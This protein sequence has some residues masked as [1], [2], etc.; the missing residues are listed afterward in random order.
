LL[1]LY[2]NIFYKIFFGFNFKIYKN[3][4]NNNNNNNNNANN[5]NNNKKI[6]SINLFLNK[7]N[8]NPCQN[9]KVNNKIY[10]CDTN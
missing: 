6:H 7:I 9:K 3:N 8:D 4:A 10:F 1:N 2:I 5:N